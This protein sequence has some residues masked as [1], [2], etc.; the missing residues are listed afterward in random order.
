[1]RNL[2]LACTFAAV[3]L[4]AC[5]NVQPTASETQSSQTSQVRSYSKDKAYPV[6]IDYSKASN[7]IRRDE[8]TK[9]RV[10][11]FYLHPTASFDSRDGVFTEVEDSSYRESATGAYAVQGTAFASFANVYA[12]YYRQLTFR[13]VVKF[14]TPYALARYLK[15]SRAR[16]DVYAALDTFFTRYNRQRPFILAGHSQGSAVLQVILEDYMRQHPEYLKRMIAVYAIG[17]PFTQAW[18]QRNPHVK[19]ARSETDT[20]V[21]ITWNTEGPGAVKSFFSDPNGICINPL[22]WKVNGTQAS[23]GKNKGTLNPQTGKVEEGS[24]DA[25]INLARKTLVCST[26]PE[27]YIQPASDFFG[28]KSLHYL[29][30]GLYYMNIRT[31]AL[32]RTLAYLSRKNATIPLMLRR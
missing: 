20:G 16:L 17:F 15:K 13:E 14:E 3:T 27:A 25:R 10:D 21:V 23:V 11:V 32:R 19:P 31:N 1:M 5:T 2:I 12:P 9:H 6:P 4:S 28:D 24:A 7:W 29:D 18:F 22:N 30:Y 8:N 26:H